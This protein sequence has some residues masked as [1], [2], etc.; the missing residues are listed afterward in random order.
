M[1]KKIRVMTASYKNICLPLAEG[2][3][4]R[5]FFADLDYTDSYL[6]NHKENGEQ[7]Y[8]YPLVQYKVIG[9]NP[10]II[11]LED[12][13]R[14]IHPHLMEQTSLKLGDK[15]YTDMALD[16]Q[17]SQLPLGDSKERRQYQF[18]TPWLALNQSNYEKYIQLEK[19]QQESLLNHIL[20]GNILSMCK[21][22]EVTIENRLTVTHQLK[23][24]SV[25]YKGK[26][27]AGFIGSFQINCCIPNLC[28]IGKGTARGFGA[29]RTQPIK[30]EMGNGM[31]RSSICGMD[32]QYQ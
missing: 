17:L 29:V 22:F 18:L 19:E 28:G 32:Y 8:K 5:G 1:I 30:G 11:A 6:H 3:K 7:I 15:V 31:Q 14:S 20:A 16:I 13:I 27:M 23:S 26:K 9:G 2:K 12:G 4:I 25:W 24:T 10:V 21:R